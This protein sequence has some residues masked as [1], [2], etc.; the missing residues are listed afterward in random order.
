MEIGGRFFRGLVGVLVSWVLGI[1]SYRRQTQNRCTDYLILRRQRKDARMRPTVPPQRPTYSPYLACVVTMAFAG[2]LNIEDSI[3]Q[4]SLCAEDGG[5]AECVGP[6]VTEYQHWVGST[7]VPGTIG[8]ISSEAAGIASVQTAVLAS[9]NECSS[10]FQ[11]LAWLPMPAGAPT[12]GSRRVDVGAN[13]WSQEWY[14]GTEVSQGKSDHRIPLVLATNSSPPCATQYTVKFGANRSRTADCPAGYSANPPAYSHCW[15]AAGIKPQKNFGPCLDCEL[16]VGNPVNVATGNRYLE[17]RDYVG[18]GAFPL[19]YTRHYNSLA[20]TPSQPPTTGPRVFTKSPNWQGTYDRVVLLT[21]HPRF[22]VARAYRHTGR[23]ITF[24]QSGTQWV[25]D[26]D[27]KERLTQLFDGSGNPAGWTLTTTSDET[28]T[29][30]SEGKLVLLRSR[31]GVTQSLSYNVKGK[32][33]TVTH[34]FGGQLIFGYDTSGRLATMTVP[35]GAQYAY[36][37]NA[38]GNLTSLTY[39]DGATR[40]YHYENTSWDHALT[41]ITDESAARFS[42]YSYDTAGRASQTQHAGGVDRFVFTYPTS[43]T[44]VVTDPMNTARTWTHLSVLGSARAS[45]ISQ[46]CPTCSSASK[47][48]TFDA[49]A[50]IAT[51]TDFNN[52]V[53]QYAY[54]MPRNLETSRTDAIGTAQARTTTTAWHATYRLPTQIEEPGRRTTFIHDTNGNVLSKTITDTGTNASRTWTYTYSSVGQVLTEDGPRTDVSDT[55]TYTYYSCTTG[56]ECGQLHTVTNA[57]G[58]VTTYNSYNA[59]GQPLSI[60]DPNGIVTTFTYD[61]RQRPKTRTVAGETTSFDYWPTGLLKK[62]TQPHGSYLSYSYDAAHRLTGIADSE[63]NRIAYT[64]DNLGNRTK[65]E[66][67]DPSNALASTRSRVFNTL[68]QLQKELGAAGTAA[69]T[70]TFSYDTNGN[71]TSVAAP[72]GRTTGQAYDELN[73][74]TQVT[75]PA[76]GVTSYGYDSLDQLIS[77]TDPRGKVTSYTYS[78]L[79][80]MTQ[81][82]SPDTGT[83]TSTYDEVGNLKTRTDAR[84]KT[85]TYTYDALDRVTELSYPD[86]TIT[87]TYDQGLNGM[88]RLSSVSDGSGSTAWTYDDHGRVLSRQQVMSGVSKSISYSY[89]TSGRLQSWTLPSGNTISVGYTD[90]KVT[91]LTLNGSTTILSSVLYRPFGPSLGWTW[92]NGTLAV[93]EYDTDG[94][95]TD[96]DSAGLKTYSYDDAFRITGVVDGSNSAL[97][98]SYGYDS[99]DRL[100]AAAGT[101]LNQTW[102]YDANG[103]RLTQGG[104]TG[105]SY[106]IASSSNRISA[107]SGALVRTYTYDAAGNTTTDGLATYTYDD[108]GRMVSATRGGVTGVYSINALGQRVRKFVGGNSPYFTYDDSGHLIGEY[109][110]GGTLIQETVWLGDAPVATLRPKVGGGV[111]VFYVHTDHLNTPRR[112]SR[113]SDSI[114]VWRWDSDPFGTVQVNEDP[115]GDAASFVYNLRFP[116]QYFDSETGLHYNYFRDYDPYTARY[117]QSDPI[118]LNGGVNTYRYGYANPTK[119]IDAYGLSAADVEE[120]R[121]DISTNFPEILPRGGWQ[122]EKR[123]AGALAQSDTS[124]GR[125]F[126]DEKYKAE[127]ISYDEFSAL[128]FEMLHESM[129]S[130]DS[131]AQRTWDSAWW[132]LFEVNTANHQAIY[133]RVTLE[134]DRIIPKGVERFWGITRGLSPTP[135]LPKGHVKDL[136]DRRPDACGCN[137]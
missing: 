90:G 30:D 122:F 45:A 46:L 73:R 43:T 137:N 77:V 56:F 11:Y 98:Q 114:I 91:S 113:H 105:S 75:D 15:R 27:V 65:E 61:A 51:R 54:D 116:G 9:Q 125:I 76:S 35:G 53:T 5:T 34:S 72:L 68:N 133:D 84:T 120:I 23:V 32:L 17:E 94:K 66:T 123:N 60:T 111:D 38:Q 36:V 131:K 24:K 40:T 83:T 85:G 136:Y 100:T 87:Y 6:E 55:T 97:S 80:D 95:V 58:H 7:G 130:T 101:G 62:V 124:T 103:N 112:V 135:R 57:V 89:N 126:V 117:L 20:F 70:T 21:E 31:A 4:S 92:G 2:L 88:G 110:T 121:N 52:V 10:S 14:L 12:G 3:A 39:P 96:I 33:I 8:P 93:R 128:Y 119:Y 37:Y 99:L 129:H 118:G 18:A 82:V 41:G 79:G 109:G 132:R 48:K 71:M 115:D 69:V 29:Y 22:P 67:F 106:T 1:E 28:E 50:N 108:S 74:M 63:G 107:V 78:T 134:E 44:T 13:S 127:C 19:E 25:A 86:Q 47:A 16:Q 81:Q 59:H 42:T 26:A 102:T 104:S 64:L 49:N